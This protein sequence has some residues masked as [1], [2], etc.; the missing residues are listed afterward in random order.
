[1][2]ERIYYDEK[3]SRVILTAR[4]L[5]SFASGGAGIPFEAKDTGG[6]VS[7][8]HE[9]VSAELG[10]T[11][12]QLRL[13]GVIEY[14][15]VSPFGTAVVKTVKNSRKNA[16]PE[17]HT[18]DAAELAILGLLACRNSSLDGVI[19][20]LV[21]ERS[22]SDD[23][24][25]Y[26][27]DAKYLAAA[28]AALIDR[29]LPFA[30][31]I[32]DRATDG[33]PAMRALPFPY[34]EIRESQHTFIGEAFRAIK[35]GR[36]LLVS[37]PTGTGKTISALYPAVR[38][39]GDGACDKIFCLCAKSTVGRVFVSA[40]SL[41]AEHAPTLKCVVISSKERCCPVY[42]GKQS[43]PQRC[44]AFCPLTDKTHGRRM[45]AAASECL[46]YS[47]IDADRIAAAA[48]KHR[49]C[50]HELSLLISEYA[51]IV[52]CDYNY[53]FDFRIRLKRFFDN[54]TESDALSAPPEKYVFLA[55]EV[56][57][58]PKRASDTYSAELSLSLINELS[59]TAAKLEDASPLRDAASSLADAMEKVKKS[60]LENG[61]T[62]SIGGNPVKSGFICS[63]DLPEGLCE[64]AGVLRRVLG[65]YVFC[66]GMTLPK[67]FAE[68]GEAVGKLCHISS[69]F[70]E[71]YTFFASAIG[72]DFYIRLI[73]LDPSPLLASALSVA[74]SVI[75]FSA[76]LS[77]ISYY[78]DMLGCKDGAA[79]ELESP[80]PPEN[81]CPIAV[82][83]ISMK[84]SDRT[85]SAPDVAEIIAATAEA[86]CGNYL[87]FFPSFD[88]MEKV[89]TVFREIMPEA[90]L[91]V[92]SRSMGQTERTEFLS[93][94]TRKRDT[95]G[96]LV[97][98]AV[99]GGIFS[100]GIDLPGSALIGVIIAGTGM[101]AITS[102][103]NIMKE[104]FDKTREC[105]MEYAYIYPGM[106]SVL[107]AAGRVIRKESDRGV[108]VLI[109]DRYAEP[110]YYKLFP[111]SYR[112]IKYT[113]DPFSLGEILRRFWEKDGTVPNMH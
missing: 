19:L 14:M 11:L 62:S 110:T 24:F 80:F 57:N 65:S 96:T 79:L 75:F 46:A 48:A 92:Q 35:K 81:L 78:A 101:P 82:D 2:R 13:C 108:L 40:A 67:I 37:A 69:L 102:E 1:M 4:A 12:D 104:Y 98:F 3:E 41:L 76:T 9:H 26:F 7:A 22:D 56:H 71:N 74:T 50:P 44:S 29:A 72:D 99:L 109:D 54:S 23:V 73:C 105:G 112:H 68:A 31:L 88:S 61:E 113:G 30:R 106:N 70:G 33:I 95:P 47:V 34:P 36:R 97:G 38:A 90:E 111:R 21:F 94:F 49:V 77:P 100:E 15:T 58:L 66:H 20:R 55:D 28:T 89:L 18:S 86:R 93:T 91:V 5:A 103:R 87:A 27:A 42:T 83:S 8:S 25:E 6:T 84:L 85:A 51:D 63:P 43:R 60:A 39:I 52:V 17:N 45:Y 10:E 59:A 53:V 107:Q 32:R 64:A 16:T